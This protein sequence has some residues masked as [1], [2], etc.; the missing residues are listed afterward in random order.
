MTGK[1]PPGG[2][3][4]RR[5]PSSH[6]LIGRGEPRPCAALGAPT[7]RAAQR[8][9][10]PSLPSPPPQ[11]CHAASAVLPDGSSDQG[12]NRI[13]L[14]PA[15]RVGPTGAA[16]N[17]HAFWDSGA[18]SQ[19]SVPSSYPPVPEASPG[20]S[21]A[22]VAAFV[23]TLGPELEAARA[24][25]GSVSAAALADRAGALVGAWHQESLRVRRIPET[26]S[27]EIHRYPQ[28]DASAVHPC[29]RTPPP[30]PPAR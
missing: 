15:V 22:D 13:S 21:D 27:T 8:R 10:R 18:T 9:T 12:A 24:A 26:R 16:S 14:I 7:T 25:V 17:L 30:L 2:Q 29:P 5:G 20:V 28:A 6:R 3:T 1:S 11:P 23:G 4:G 19:L